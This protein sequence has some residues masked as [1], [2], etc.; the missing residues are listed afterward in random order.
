MGSQ[1]LSYRAAITAAFALGGLSA[2]VM[3]MIAG[4]RTVRD[5]DYVTW[6]TAGRLAAANPHALYDTAA[7]TAVQEQLLGGL[8][9]LG[10]RTFGSP[11]PVAWLFAPLS[12]LSL[13]AGAAVFEIVS[14][15]SLLA[16]VVMLC[17][18]WP[19]TTSRRERIMTA[20]CAVFTVAAVRVLGLAQIDCLILP[21]AALGMVC[22]VRG[23]GF[24]AGLALSVMLIKPQLIWV[25]LPVLLITGHRATFLGMLTGVGLGGVVAT[26]LVGP[27]WPS[28]WA[29]VLSEPGWAP[30]LADGL[31]GLAIRVGQQ[32]WLG[33]AVALVGALAGLAWAWRMRHLL[34]RDLPVTLALVIPFSM[35]VAPHVFGEDASMLALPLALCVSRRPNA[36]LTGIVIIDILE[37]MS[38]TGAYQSTVLDPILFVVAMVVTL[39]WVRRLLTQMSPAKA[40]EDGTHVIGGDERHSLPSTA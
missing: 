31:P 18:L 35:L 30:A 34:R 36:G 13:T 19:S 6:A 4:V 28:G 7:Q 32:P 8:P 2:A 26:V 20:G 37:G 33:S 24:S 39:V 23:R 16:A 25:A 11:P 22:A 17:R 40:D 14:L 3:Q 27:A 15:L 38:T 12:P 21:A 9:P 10:L 5:S 1:R 29:T